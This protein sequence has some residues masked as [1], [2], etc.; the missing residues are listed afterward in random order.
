MSLPVPGQAAAAAAPERAET[1]TPA[2]STQIAREPEAPQTSGPART[3]P[4][5]R[6]SELYRS[7]PWPRLAPLPA[8][9]PV[10]A[11]PDPR[12]SETP[13]DV[14]ARLEARFSAGISSTVRGPGNGNKP[15][16]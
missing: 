15:G 1:T 14:T 13:Q 3:T 8:P 2:A 7:Q 5:Q 6:L 10:P 9:E 4:Q 12:G 11:P 16:G